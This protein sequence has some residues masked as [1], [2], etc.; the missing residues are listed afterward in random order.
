MIPLFNIPK[1]QIDTSKFSHSLNGKNVKEFENRFCKYV[2]GKYIV[3][4]C[5]CTVAIQ[6]VFAYLDDCLNVWPRIKIPAVLPPVVYNAL[7]HSV[8][9]GNILFTEDHS[10]VGSSYE[11]QNNFDLKIIDSAQDLYKIKKEDKNYIVF[12]SFYPTKPVGGIDGG[13]VVTDNEN[14]AE[15]LRIAVNNGMTQD[16]NS[17]LRNWVFPGYKAYM[18]SSQAYCA[19]KA[20]ESWEFNRKKK[21]IAIRDEFNSYFRLQNTSLHLYRHPVQEY[22]FNDVL[23]QLDCDGIITGVHYRPLFDIV[24]YD[25]GLT[26]EQKNEIRYHLYISIPFHSELTDEDITTIEI[27]VIHAID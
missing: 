12:Y 11:I 15:W 26:E 13:A 17:W 2:N 20:L 6:L 5:S 21:M 16:K 24:G 4:T 14:L 27:D 3:S 1:F 18:S 10:W 25:G 7:Y 23:E 8:G 19:D 9:H 22:E